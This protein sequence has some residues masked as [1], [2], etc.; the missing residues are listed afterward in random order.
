[1]LLGGEPISTKKQ[2]Q[3][4]IDFE[5]RLANITTPSDMRRDEESLYNLISLSELQE[6]ADFV[7][8]RNYFF[9]IHNFY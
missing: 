3:D 1:M 6:K 4:I 5:T 9:F 7:R 8:R 2:M